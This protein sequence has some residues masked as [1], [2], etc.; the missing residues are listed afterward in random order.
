MITNPTSIYFNDY[1]HLSNVKR[2]S[3]FF[4]DYEDEGARKAQE[5]H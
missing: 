2:D 4:T 1:S 5:L 3:D